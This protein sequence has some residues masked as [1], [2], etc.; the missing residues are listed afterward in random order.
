MFDRPMRYIKYTI[1]KHNARPNNP[2][3]V[4]LLHEGL[5]KRNHDGLNSVKYKMLGMIKYPR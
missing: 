4:K 2:N 5:N 3:R 1:L